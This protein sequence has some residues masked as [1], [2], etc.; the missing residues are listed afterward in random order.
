MSEEKIYSTAVYRSFGGR[1]QRFELPLREMCELER[2]CGAGIAAIYARVAMLQFYIL[3]V[4]QT[5][6]LGMIGGGSTPAEAE[7]TVRFNLDGRP[8]NE[9]AQLAADILNAA[10]E[11]TEPSKKAS[12][13]EP[14]G[15]PETSGHSTNSEAPPASVPEKSTQ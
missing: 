7:A 5:I 4:R 15:A 6:R 1:D 2:L 9:Y 14:S 13:A 3:D 11:G 12:G 8:I 10:F